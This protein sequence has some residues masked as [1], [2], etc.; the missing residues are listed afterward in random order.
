MGLFYER[1][2]VSAMSKFFCLALCLFTGAWAT[3]QTT[4]HLESFEIDG[5]GY[6]TSPSEF[7]QGDEDFYL[8]TSLGTIDDQFDDFTNVQGTW[9]FA[10][11]DVDEGGVS[12]ATLTIMN[13]DISNHENLM[14]SGFFAEDDDGSNNDWDSSDYLHIS[15]SIDGGTPSNLLWIENDGSTFN[16]APFVDTNFDGTGDGTEITQAFQEL[17]ASISGTGSLLTLVI[18]I[19][20]NSGD[21][22]IAFDELKV[23]GDFVAPPCSI[24]NLTLTSAPACGDAPFQDDSYFEL[25]YDVAGGTG[26]Y[27]MLNPATNISYGTTGLA[28]A[29]M[30]GTVTTSGQSS[31]TGVVEG[32]TVQVV[33]V[34][35]GNA[36]C[37]SAPLDIF[38]PVC[39]A[40]PVCPMAGDLVI[41]EVMQNPF[42]LGDSAGEYFEIYNASSDA[43]ELEGMVV[44]DDGSDDFTIAGSLVINPGE[45]MVFANGAGAAPT[46]D[47]VYSGMFLSNSADELIL[48]IQCVDFP[49]MEIDRV[50]WDG[51]ATWPDPTGSSMNL[52]S[53]ELAG[54]NNDGSNWCV[55]TMPFSTGD[56]GTPGMA[57]TDCDAVLPCAITNLMV[58]EDPIC[59][60]TDVQF[61]VRFATMSGS[62]EYA[63]INADDDTEYG[64]FLFGAETGPGFLNGTIPGPVVA[65][66]INIQVIDLASEGTCESEPY[67]I[68]IPDC[69]AF[70]PDPTE[71]CLGDI[72]F[73][74][75]VSDGTSS[76]T[77][78][79]SFI[80]LKDVGSTTEI[81]FTDKGWTSG[82]GFV[83][84]E[85]TA[86]VTFS[87][88]APCGI[89]LVVTGTTMTD[90]FGNL[91]G[92][93]TNS[94][95]L[96][97]GG[98]Q[99]FA[100][101]GD[102][103]TTGDMSGFIAAIQ[104]NSGTWE[105]EAFNS[106]ASALPC[107]FE[108]G[109][110]AV[111][112]TV[113]RDNGNYTCSVISGTPAEL[114]AAINDAANWF[115]DSTPSNVTVPSACE[116]ACFISECTL[117]EIE[118]ATATPVG[119]CP[120]DPIT[121]EVNG[122]LG[123][124]TDWA[125]YA[126]CCGGTPFATGESVDVFPTE[127][128]TYYV[129]GIGGCVDV[130][131]CDAVAVEA[132][133]DDERPSFNGTCGDLDQSVS[134][135]EGEC[136]TEVYL[137]APMATDNCDENLQI[138]GRYRSI[139]DG[140]P[141]SWSSWSADPSGYFE[142]GVY[143]IQWRAR[144]DSGNNRRCKHDLIVTDDEDP[145]LECIDITIEFNGETFQ[146]FDIDDIAT[147]SD[148]CGVDDTDISTSFVSCA[149]I[150][151]V[152]PVE[153]TVYDVNGGSSTC[154]AYVTVDGLPCGWMTDGHVDCEGE[155][156]YTAATE[157]F[158]LSSEDCHNPITDDDDEYA[159]I[160]RTLCGNASIT[161]EVTDISGSANGWAGVTFRESNDPDSKMV[162]WMTNGS[163]NHRREV[164]STTGGNVTS[165]LAPSFNRHWLRIVRVGNSFRG[166]SSSNGSSWFLRFSLSVPMDECVEVGLIVNSYVSSGNATA[167][168]EN[169]SI[170][171]GGGQGLQGVDPSNNESLDVVRNETSQPE[172]S[173]FTAPK[174]FTVYP[175]PSF[176]E[177][178]LAIGEYAEQTAIVNVLDGYGRVVKTQNLGRIEFTT[179]NLDLRELPAGVYT[180]QLQLEDGTVNSQRIVLQPR[181]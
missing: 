77:E 135:T 30:N 18:E 160:Q 156:D 74:G 43:L 70:E 113:E 93:A 67:E 80:L 147:Y 54:D 57:N 23:T 100:Y 144:D 32:T 138:R 37:M 72:A 69:P 106:N 166:Y 142:V 127:N 71:L 19:S 89:E 161:A 173:S 75:Y 42:N 86:V 158:I 13:I 76:T 101:Q 141:G 63:V 15:Y 14:F 58:S 48:T 3:G 12:P 176:G 179:A 36:T 115:V 95:A 66:T 153:V 180:I 45:Y 132:L 150:D 47:Y 50:E 108:E 107:V 90:V 136:G 164:R 79:W 7:D 5:S 139:V 94:I 125:W 22:D 118:V 151:E 68:T 24:T 149:Q 17:T 64:R 126:D 133:I 31:V 49:S 26:D 98:D 131:K 85:G 163:S 169:V 172:G 103:P 8:R 96:S 114:R 55:S 73:T 117:P 59:D 4:L 129:R 62:G 112:P 41:T 99:L 46:V 146:T 2:Q 154:T 16:S 105:V 38:V 159:F 124:A 56:F 130:S 111:A 143:E 162:A 61:T 168:F 40:V 20:L 81:S 52:T 11:C 148:N 44:S 137:P 152:I 10:G 177:V 157:T 134:A 27:I 1:K 165:Q 60:G 28:G 109:L 178:Q 116:F 82:A 88:P 35:A 25:Q 97:T 87:R 155:A 33:V 104:M 39:P 29:A 34:D 83:T 119:N 120:D 145:A 140:D 6:S 167:M 9:F 78:R 175:N 65:G 91:Y 123:D 51:G 174:S 121:L 122:A 53:T 102:E 21:E 128:T 171:G 170:T 92:T 84:N 110:T 181:P